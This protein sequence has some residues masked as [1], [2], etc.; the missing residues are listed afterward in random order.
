MLLRRSLADFFPPETGVAPIR[1]GARPCQAILFRLRTAEE[2]GR[3]SEDEVE[4][5]GRDWGAGEVEKAVGAKGGD[6][7]SG[8]G[9]SGADVMGA[10]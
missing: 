9:E 6:E 2:G 5:S 8:G 10:E 4:E 7:G 1:A 3:V